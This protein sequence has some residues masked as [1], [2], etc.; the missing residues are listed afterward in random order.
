[1]KQETLPGTMLVPIT[2][3]QHNAIVAHFNNL[4]AQLGAKVNTKRRAE[5]MIAYY[6]GVQVALAAVG[7]EAGARIVAPIMLGGREPTAIDL[8]PKAGG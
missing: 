2:V 1:M 4:A 6:S 3:E 7:Y 5:A 8:T